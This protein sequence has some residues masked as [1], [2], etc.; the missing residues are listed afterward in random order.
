M[1][2]LKGIFGVRKVDKPGIYLG[3]NMDFSLRKGSLF[4]RVL[5][6]VR[7]KLGLW[8]ALLLAFP[9][10][11]ILV[12]HVLLSIPSYLLS[13]F[14][15][16]LYFLNK[17]KRVALRFLWFGDKGRGLAWRKWEVLCLPKAKGGLGLRD[18]SCLNQALL[19]KIAWRMLKNQILYLPKC[20]WANIATNKGSFRLK[21]LRQ[22]RGAGEV[23]Y[24]VRSC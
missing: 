14:R 2:N 8:K 13:V 11:L 20:W 1:A 6:R 23:F 16:P 5:D 9:S 4:S 22:F 21:G 24:G 18:L 7:S 10:H 19:A 15:A 12:K 3:A 17:I